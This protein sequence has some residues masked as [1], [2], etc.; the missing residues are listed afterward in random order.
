M[1]LGNL[2]SALMVGSAVALLFLSFWLIREERYQLAAGRDGIRYYN[3]NMNNDAQAQ[4]TLIAD[5]RKALL[6]DEFTLHYQSKIDLKTG[7]LCGCEAL[8]RWQHHTRGNVPPVEF[9]Q[10]AERSGLIVEIGMWVMQQA[11]QALHRFDSQG[12]GELSMA[13]NVSSLQFRRGNLDRIVEQALAQANI[14][15][16]RLEIEM[17]ESMLMEPGADIDQTFS[18]LQTLGV[19]FSIDDFG[20]GYS[21][22][23]YLNKMKISIL[24]IDRSF[25]SQIH[26]SPQDTAIVTAV[27]QMANSLNLV[28]VAEGA[29]TKAEADLLT[30]LGCTQGQGYYWG[31]PMPE[32]KFVAYALA[33]QQSI[34]TDRHE[35]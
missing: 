13:V 26:L 18:R 30:E 1:A 12:I 4:V 34:K 11:M 28:T 17:T 22:L 24:K 27:I 5:L 32:D 33:Q 15:P 14:A 23:G 9:I 31:K 19:N 10:L 25:V 6:A 29:E 7:A 21:N 35:H 20:T 16:D 2:S 8:L 3:T